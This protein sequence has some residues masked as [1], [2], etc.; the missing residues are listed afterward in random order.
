M[1]SNKSISLAN[2][3]GDEVNRITALHKAIREGIESGRAIDFHPFDC[4]N[5]SRQGS[6]IFFIVDKVSFAFVE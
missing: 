1:K 4:L 5:F 3:V 2:H 6:L